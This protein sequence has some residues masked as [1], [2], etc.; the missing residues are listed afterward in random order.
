VSVIGWIELV[1]PGLAARYWDRRVAVTELKRLYEAAQSSQYHRAR[2]QAHSGDAVMDHAGPKLRHHAR[3]LDENHDFSIGILDVLVNRTV[4]TGIWPAPMTKRRDGTLHD[5]FNSALVKAFLS[6]ARRPDT[7]GEHPLPELQR[8]QCRTWLRDGEMLTQHM[9][10]GRFPHLGEVPYTIELL[11]ADYLP[12]E[13]HGSNPRVVHGVEKG[14]GG[15]PVAYHLLRDHPG[16]VGFG[17]TGLTQ[18]TIRVPA[19]RVDHLKF[20]R[21]IRQTRGASIFSGVLRTL[22]D[23]KDMEESERI[24][25]RVAAAFT[26]FIRKGGDYGQTGAVS[27]GSRTFEMSPGLIFDG[28]APGEDIGTIASNRPNTNLEQFLAGQH[29]RVAAGTGVS[30]S[31]SSKNYNGTYSAQRQELVESDVGYARL[32]SY[33]TSKA[34]IPMWERFVDAAILAGVVR[35]PRELDL[36]TLRDIECVRPPM[37]WIDPA[38][39]V[40]ADSQRVE[41][42]FASRHQIIRER[43]GDPRRVDAERDQDTTPGVSA[44]PAAAAGDDPETV[45]TEEAA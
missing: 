25:A 30:Y 15:R 19:D 31:S 26:G 4:G 16:D 17:R 6:W 39:E 42:G 22:E 33:F 10:G 36:G 37:P 23:I 13:L 12:F 1:A 27:A 9:I 8:Q 14:I 11:E 44:T 34:V 40:A 43:G 41:A 7:E 38:K 24:A 35:V 21:R 18:Q 29:R 45:A 28:L 2:N 5:D 3:Y 20:V 32:H